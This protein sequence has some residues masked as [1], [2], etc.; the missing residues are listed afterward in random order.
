MER[1]LVSAVIPTYQRRELAL[2]AVRSAL[3]QRYEPFEVIVVDDGSADGTVEA[4]RG[5]DPRLVVV[6]CEHAGLSATRNAGV[7]RAR[8]SIVAF[9]DSD[10]RWLPHHLTT[11][12]EMLERL[13]E[14]VLATTAR[15]YAA[16]GRQPPRAAR[17]VDPMPRIL[18]GGFVGPISCVAVRR[19]A[20]D[21]AG[22]FATGLQYAEET[23]LYRRLALV[24]PFATLRSRTGVVQRTRG[25]MTDQTRAA[26]G[27]FAAVEIG[28]ARL[29]E[30]VRATP[31]AAELGPRV[32]GARAFMAALAAAGAGDEAQVAAKLREACALLPE[33]RSEPVLV[34]GRVLAA[35]GG[36]GDSS[37]AIATV[38]RLW[39]GE[40]ETA[41]ALRAY[42]AL[43]SLASGHPRR[44]AAAARGLSLRST[45]QLARHA[46]AAGLHVWKALDRRIHTGQESPLLAPVAAAGPARSAP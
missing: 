12:T 25:A 35:L 15:D 5:L 46:P 31:R 39:P 37:P 42:A 26:R 17:V 30:R 23:D 38:A 28:L 29:G 32:D 4:L 22:P 33:L 34:L 20:L 24:G 44:A 36:A 1:P 2:R 16:F 43:S 7:D 19:Q 10:D 45:V 21:E 9:L 3:A 11:V 41:A 8:G 18:I 40:D 14:A 27:Q 13:P 6:A